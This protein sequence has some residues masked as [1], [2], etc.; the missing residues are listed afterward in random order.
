M[1]VFVLVLGG[2]FAV[3]SVIMLLL[4]KMPH[5]PLANVL[6]SL[7]DSL[8]L[9]A[10]LCPLLWLLVVRPLRTLVGQRGELLS[11]TLTIQEEERARLARD[12]HD[13]LGQAQT[14][15]LLGLA[16]VVKARNLDEARER[17]A[18][19][20]EMAVSAVESSR[21]LARGL[22]PGVL[23]DFGLQVAI[24]RICEDLAAASDI[25]LDLDLR[26]PRLRFEAPIEIAVYRVVQE[27][28]TNAAKHAGAKVIRVQ[29]E[30]ANSRVTLAV[31]DDGR[32]MDWHKP[33]GSEGLGL[34]GMQERTVLLGGRFLIGPSPSGGTTV[35][36]SL[37]ASLRAS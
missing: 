22:S 9:I 2:V 37:P 14:A 21:R 1:R 3:E 26:I 7:L 28:L 6:L 33:K 23:A 34:A 12:L 17:A 25:A 30:Y 10:V 13:E 31:S 5:T 11:R 20:H 36:A 29:L 18:G 35:S 32:G 8:T 24:E 4:P 15:V 27:A 16:A 19:V